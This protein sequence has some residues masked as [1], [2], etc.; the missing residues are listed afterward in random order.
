MLQSEYLNAER[1]REL[2]SLYLGDIKFQRLM[3]SAQCMI[4]E[5]CL[6]GEDCC[7]MSVWGGSELLVNQL[8][9]RLS[10]LGFVCVLNV[11]DLV[12]CW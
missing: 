6:R 8:V 5:A 1:A 2:T 9:D 10:G 4:R 7:K 11:C 3:Q 12:I